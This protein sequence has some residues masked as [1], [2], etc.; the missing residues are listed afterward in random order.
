MIRILIVD[1]RF[2]VRQAL[3]AI[4]KKDDNFKIVGEAENGIKALEIISKEK[5]DI[6]IVDLDMPEMNGFEFTQNISQH[7]HQTKVIILSSHDDK[8]SINRAISCGARGYLIKDTSITEVVDTINR[9]QR[10]YFQLG[11]GLF[12]K[13]IS[14]S[15]SYE[16]KTIEHLSDLE[17]KL[18][19]DFMR[20]RQQI[21]DENQQV[22]Q[23][24]LIEID[25]EIEQLKHELKQ[26]LNDFEHRAIQHLKD[27]LKDCG[28][29]QENSH[30]SKLQSNYKDIINNLDLI[31]SNYQRSFSKFTKELMILRRCIIFILLFFLVEKALVLWF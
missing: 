22:R 17:T 26:G 6:A 29:R 9:V 7:H 5:I 1:D 20:L 21:I 12:E 2:L 11:P 16:V 30:H 10:G 23:E 19:R 4:L 14:E 13:L 15:N 3:R 27:S 28:D 31:E 24:I 8:E 18:E 25:R